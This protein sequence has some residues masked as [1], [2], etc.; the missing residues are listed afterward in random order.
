MRATLILGGI[1]S[2]SAVCQCLVAQEV[3]LSE[4]LG[5]RDAADARFVPAELSFAGAETIADLIE[6]PDTDVDVTV[7]LHCALHV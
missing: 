7:S 6:F 1:V 3:P 5:S 4:N 2:F